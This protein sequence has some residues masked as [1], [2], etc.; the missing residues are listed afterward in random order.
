MGRAVIAMTAVRIGARIEPDKVSDLSDIRPPTDA[1]AIMS[2]PHAQAN[3]PVSGFPLS[4]HPS[5]P[6]PGAATSH[7][8]KPR[9]PSR[10]PL[11]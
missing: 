2:L 5:H 1:M 8:N 7:R 11:S 6:S 3:H 10:I 4:A 9:N